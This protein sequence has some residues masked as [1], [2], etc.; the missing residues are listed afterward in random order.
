MTERENFKKNKLMSA[1]CAVALIG[2][3]FSTAPETAL[4]KIETYYSGSTASYKG[5]I[6][7]ATANTGSVELFSVENGIITK[8]ANLLSPSAF[9]PVI[10]DVEL[11]AEGDRL[12]AYLVN[13][14]YVYKYD[15]SNPTFPVKIAEA[16][17]NSWE[18]YKGITRIDG[19]I[20]LVGKTETK[21]INTDLE[22]LNSYKLTNDFYD[23][24]TSNSNYIFNV[25]EKSNLEIIDRKLRTVVSSFLLGAKENHNRRIYNDSSE[26]VIYAVS[27]S[28]LNKYDFSGK[29]VKSL[30]HISNLGYDVLPSKDSRYLYF[31]DGLGVVKVKKDTLKAEKWIRT[32]DLKPEGNWAMG[33]AIANDASG[34]KV[35]VFDGMSI[36]VL[37]SKL[38][39]LSSFNAYKE[40]F[41]PIAPAYLKADKIRGGANTQVSVHGGGFGLGEKISVSLAGAKWNAQTDRNGDFNLVLVVPSVKAGGYDIKV[42]GENSKIS[43]NLAFQIE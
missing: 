16:L 10:Y 12:Y 33:M 38:K 32:A 20:A 37:D 29:L 34:E 13:G 6:Y 26:G 4:G 5:N 23:N 43:L 9:F 35:I 7:V 25:T 18:W 8:E 2:V 40:S 1:V 22:N 11:N 31:S 24:I 36:L 41:S 15:V 27:D 30:K 39:L 19:M 14:R 42:I 21:I 3:I 17:D 28:A